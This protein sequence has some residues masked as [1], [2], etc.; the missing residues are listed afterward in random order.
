M[1][2]VNFKNRVG[3]NLSVRTI[4]NFSIRM[5]V[6]AIAISFAIVSCGKDD[7]NDEDD[8]GNDTE[9]TATNWQKTIKDVYGFDLNVPTGWTFKKGEKT[10]INP[11]Y[12]VQFTTTAADFQ[13]ENVKFM[14]HVFDLTEKVTPATGNYDGDGKLDAIP[15]MMGFY[16]ALWHFDTPKYSIQVSLD[17]AE[18]TKTVQITLV[19]VKTF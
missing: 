6:M 16:F 4:A 18:A 10:N 11:A 17:D 19:A 12:Y 13:A 7:K 5:F 1:T 3:A 9:M 14:Q 8:G 15:V 2:R